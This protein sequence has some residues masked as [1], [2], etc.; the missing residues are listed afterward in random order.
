MATKDLKKRNKKLQK[1]K[2]KICTPPKQHTDVNT[3]STTKI[4]L[5]KKNTSNKKILHREPSSF[6]FIFNT[7]FT[8]FSCMERR[9]LIPVV[10]KR[11][12]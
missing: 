8:R 10:N 6:V 11:E 2:K 5:V 7:T 4:I 12:K 9:F 3:S 1:K